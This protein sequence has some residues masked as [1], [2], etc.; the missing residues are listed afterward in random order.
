MA[1]MN[2]LSPRVDE[3]V[4][5]LA[6]LTGEDVDTAIEQ[7]VEERLS[8][9]IPSVTPDRHAALGRFLAHVAGAAVRDDRPADEILGYGPDGLPD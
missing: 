2:I 8:R 4:H 1:T 7:A 3:L 5:Q 6:R 9:L